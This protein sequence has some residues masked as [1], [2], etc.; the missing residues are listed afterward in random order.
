MEVSRRSLGLA[1]L[2]LL[3]GGCGAGGSDRPAPPPVE[4]ADRP[5]TPPPGW[6]T[7]IDRRSGFSLPVPPGWAV[8]SGG[9]GTLIRSPD[10]LAALSI[11]ADRGS[12][13]RDTGAAEYATETIASLPG[14]RDLAGRLAGVVA[15]S[16]YESARAEGVG[17]REESGRR[18]RVT[19]AALRRPG[20]VTFAAIA[21]RDAAGGDART[22]RRI[23]RMLAGLR[24]RRPG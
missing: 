3:A 18:Q 2:A 23:E 8:H 16:P 7:V 21:F 24:G 6:R 4:Q 12:T 10:R 17:V 14:Y 20:V 22:R 13:G 19:V 1:L 11:Q 5:A 9:D 15:G